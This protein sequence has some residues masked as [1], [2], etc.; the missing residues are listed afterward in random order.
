MSKL[1]ILLLRPATIR[2]ETHFIP[3]IT[4]IPL[5]AAGSPSP[6]GVEIHWFLSPDPIILK[7]P[8]QRSGGSGQKPCTGQQST[9]RLV[10]QTPRT[11]LIEEL[12]HRS[13]TGTESVPLLECKS[14]S[15]PAMEA[16]LPPQGGSMLLAIGPPPALLPARLGK[17]H[18]RTDA[19]NN[20]GSLS[21]SS[22]T[23]RWCS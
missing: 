1:F 4:F 13:T 16:T 11:P 9:C 5:L 7:H 2:G 8:T 17:P 20:T 12:V 18:R 23:L 14:R 10:G 15:S 19:L 22:T 21:H 6:S 3:R